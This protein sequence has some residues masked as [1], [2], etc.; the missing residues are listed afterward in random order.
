MT[1][2]TRRVAAKTIAMVTVLGTAAAL[3]TA[4]GSGSTDT[5]ASI[6]RPTTTTAPASPA[7]PNPVEIDEVTTGPGDVPVEQTARLGQ[8]FEI[9]DEAYDGQLVKWRL[10]VSD[11]KSGGPEIFDPE[12]LAKAEH[13]NPQ[14]SPGM[15]FVLVKFSAT[16]QGNSNNPWFASNQTVNV[17]M[18]AYSTPNDPMGSA[19]DVQD[20]YNNFAQPISQTTDFGINPGV[21]GV[22]WAVFEIPAGATPTSVSVLTADMQQVLIELGS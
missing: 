13:R 7:P 16:N 18:R 2:T 5:D 11:V 20:T 14:P 19:Y 8:K 9:Y 6:G 10:A 4:C 12:L 21:D 1:T 15:Q 17:G 3:L 22:S